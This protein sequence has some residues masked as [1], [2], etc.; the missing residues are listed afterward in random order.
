M[1][2]LEDSQVQLYQTG[3]IGVSGKKVKKAN[4]SKE[5]G[6]ILIDDDILAEHFPSQETALA[7]RQIM[8]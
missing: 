8:S 6:M 5:S 4:N 2:G 1:R 3:Q 7:P